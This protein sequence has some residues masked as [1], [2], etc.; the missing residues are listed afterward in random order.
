MFHLLILS[1]TGRGLGYRSVRLWSRLAKVPRQTRTREHIVRSS[2]RPT[3]IAD[4]Q[5]K[6]TQSSNIFV[7]KADAAKL[8][9]ISSAAQRI[10]TSGDANRAIH[11][12]L[13]GPNRPDDEQ[14]RGF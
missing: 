5:V 1:Q 4:G 12:R 7:T 8:T 10:P 11:V 14:Y 3:R 2:R 9:L 6:R 13:P